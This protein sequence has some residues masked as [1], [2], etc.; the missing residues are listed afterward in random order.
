MSRKSWF[1]LAAVL[2]FCLSFALAVAA[3]SCP[4]LTAPVYDPPSYTASPEGSVNPGAAVNTYLDHVESYYSALASYYRTMWTL[5]ELS[6]SFLTL[7]LLCLIALPLEKIPASIKRKAVALPRALRIVLMCVAVAGTGF[8][9]FEEDQNISCAAGL[10]HT[11][12]DFYLLGYQTPAY[13]VIALAVATLC[14]GLLTFGKG[15]STGLKSAVLFGSLWVLAAQ[16]CLY[17]FD[18]EEMYLQV[19]T[20]VE[21]WAVFGFPVLSNWFCLIVAGGLFVLSLTSFLGPRV[22]G[23]GGT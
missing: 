20:S 4:K 1:L 7:A 19:T 2:M 6:E 15:F 18:H 5:P 16:T 10:L 13:T 22:W 11:L 8:F 9:V 23:V 21:K 14:V 12:K 17:L 3:L